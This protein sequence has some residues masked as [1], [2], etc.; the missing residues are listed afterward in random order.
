MNTIF[1]FVW[2]ALLAACIYGI[3]AKAAYWHIGTALLCLVM[4]FAM[5]E[6]KN[7]K[8]KPDSARRAEMQL[9]ANERR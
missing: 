1:R 5:K 6:P 8:N 4:F 9:P 3:I 2:L 7:E